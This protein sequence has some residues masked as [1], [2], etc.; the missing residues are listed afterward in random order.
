MANYEPIDDSQSDT[1]KPRTSN[2]KRSE[3]IDGYTIK[4]H[5]NGKTRWSKGKMIKGKQNGYW[6]WYR[7]DGT[8][9]RSGHFDMGEPSG[10]WITYDKFGK[11]YKITNNKTS[12]KTT[13]S[14]IEKEKQLIRKVAKLSRADD[15]TLNDQGWDSRVY[16]FGNGRYFFKFPRSETVQH[17][18]KYEIAA[19]KFIADLKTT[20]VA[21]KILWEHPD[22]AYFGY[23]GVQGKSV[24]EIV[25]SLEPAQKQLIG[26]V[27]GDFLK[28]FHKLK[29][30]GARTMTIEDESKQIQRW[31]ENSLYVIRQYFTDNEQK[32][33]RQL[34][35]ELW[36]SKLVELG[37]EPVLCNGDLHFEN[38]LYGH[39]GTVGIIDFGDVAYYDR[40]KDFLELENDKIV[41]EAVINS[42]GDS[43]PLL[44]EK[45]AAR[46]VM[47]QIINLGFYAGKEDTR[48]IE[49][50]VKKIR[51]SQ[52]LSAT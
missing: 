35:Y 23:E 29:L 14:M 40:S 11:V 45:I 26:R 41:F 8:L 48:N 47:I 34:V 28:Q 10:E 15:I 37:S 13:Q 1:T 44:M 43:S 5:A 31:Y 30:P 46:Q 33:L 25:D 52:A 38:I 22:N 4:Y 17:G 39:N 19:I 6:E 24:S 32:K 27:L 42:Y 18:Y 50:T 7:L 36:P 20:I 49:M 3:I 51:T 9:K 21:Q 16:S 12:Q 2:K